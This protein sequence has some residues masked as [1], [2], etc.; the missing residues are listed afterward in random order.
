MTMSVKPTLIVLVF[1][2]THEEVVS[3][4]ASME[5][6]SGEYMALVSL[7]SIVPKE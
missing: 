3:L 6:S 1:G 5:C 4:A 2:N 7:G